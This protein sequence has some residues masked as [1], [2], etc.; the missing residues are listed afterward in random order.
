[1]VWLWVSGMVVELKYMVVVWLLMG[2]VLWLC[3][4]VV[5][6]LVVMILCDEVLVELYLVVVT[7]DGVMSELMAEMYAAVM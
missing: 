2:V 5:W 6:C 4:R 3:A 7:D 1:M